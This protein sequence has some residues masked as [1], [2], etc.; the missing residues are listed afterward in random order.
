MLQRYKLLPEERP[1]LQFL[2]AL[3]RLKQT[4][5]FQLLVD[6]LH[7]A[8]RSIDRSNRKAAAPEFQWNQG[9][10]QFLEELLETIGEA[11]QMGRD[12]RKQIERQ[13]TPQVG[14]F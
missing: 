5:D 4:D 14:G 13:E 7:T 8:Q 3:A 11:E 1:R 12:L 2:Q 9:A 10:S 6:V